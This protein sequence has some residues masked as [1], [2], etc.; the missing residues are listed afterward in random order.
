MDAA[1]QRSGHTGERGSRGDLACPIPQ[2][3]DTWPQRPDGSDSKRRIE[4]A[5]YRRDQGGLSERGVAWGSLP[6]ARLHKVCRAAR[7]VPTES[8]RLILRGCTGK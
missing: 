2:F 1:R 4:L 3:S 5:V 6:R 7:S 8:N